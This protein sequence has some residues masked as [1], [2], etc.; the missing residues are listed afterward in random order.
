MPSL[1]RPFLVPLLSVCMCLASGA[2]AQVAKGEPAK[3]KAT[4]DGKNA[5]AWASELGSDREAAIE[6]LA[7][8]GAAS[9]PVLRELLAHADP[10]VVGAAAR[11][12]AQL[13]AA[14]AP[15]ADILLRRLLDCSS[16]WTQVHCG[17]A[18]A[19]IGPAGLGD[20]VGA[21][22]AA[23]LVHVG[24]SSIPRLRGECARA[25]V[26]IDGE[27]VPQLLAALARGA[28]EQ[29]EYAVQAL[30]ANGDATADDL[31]VA[32][33]SVK[34]PAAAE[35][36]QE[37][38]ARM[39]W[40]VLDRL[41]RADQP[42]L[43]LRALLTGPLQL[44]TMGE[45]FR[46]ELAASP[47]PVQRLPNVIWEHGS[48]HGGVLGL[49]RASE[50]ADGY[51]VDEIVLRGPKIGEPREPGVEVRATTI[52]RDRAHA[53]MRQLLVLA[54]AGLRAKDPAN[55]P[56]STSTANFHA[57]V[58]LE[59]AGK[60]LLDEAFAGYPSGQN[61]EVRFRAQA[62]TAVLRQATED[63]QWQVRAP[64]AADIEL[65]E[66]RCGVGSFGQPKWVTERLQTMQE[67]LGKR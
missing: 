6:R 32:L 45:H 55:V 7:A 51:R 40:R 33:R 29:H 9:V 52:A 17:N 63:A 67:L 36:V 13:G 44:V 8:H 12:G 42:E 11:A 39:G 24:Q 54:E 62:A 60:V 57:A 19:A 34:S 15:L 49:Y 64:S 10:E 53:V 43:A 38:L 56:T 37:A 48:G 4:L 18:L 25:W 66:K 16:W 21:V 14:A 1:R 30:V 65:V 28:F 58:R 46:L 2:L 59:Q 27:F 20:K 26:Q 5:A 41:E 35:V 3:G 22:R 31:L 23:L 50:T 47:P 61:I